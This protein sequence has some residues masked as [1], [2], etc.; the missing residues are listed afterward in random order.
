MSDDGNFFL[1]WGLHE[2]ERT[3]A[4]NYLWKN[5]NFLDVTIAC[6]DDQIDAHKVI[7]SAAS[8]LFQNI[9]KRNP[10]SHPLIYL[11][12]TVKKDVQAILEFIY[13]G[14]TNILQEELQD[15]M[16]LATSLK[17]KGLVSGPV[18]I[19]DAQLDKSDTS[20][21]ETETSIIEKPMEVHID[22][23]EEF[24][25][26]NAETI[27]IGEFDESIEETNEKDKINESREEINEQAINTG[28]SDLISENISNEER[29][30][31]CPQNKSGG[32]EPL[33]IFDDKFSQFMSNVYDQWM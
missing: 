32:N 19:E 6:D 4:L 31:Y 21:Q 2:Q 13:S 30:N 16:T 12:G 18:D 8:P 5:E 27:K 7:L 3:S 22:I 9:L 25:K 20:L 1:S 28:M 24:L 11:R 17:V 14:E 26:R 23:L 29:N 33:S 10:H 15:F